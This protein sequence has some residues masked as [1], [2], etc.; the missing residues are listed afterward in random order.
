MLK[1]NDLLAKRRTTM[2]KSIDSVVQAAAG[3]TGLTLAR[4]GQPSYVPIRGQRAQ[5]VLSRATTP[6]RFG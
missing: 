3:I 4:D 1:R 5:P 2:K 6:A